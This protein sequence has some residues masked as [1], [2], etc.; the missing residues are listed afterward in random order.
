MERTI[1]ASLLMLA[2]GLHSSR[3]VA[4]D[5]PLIGGQVNCG[6]AG[7]LSLPSDGGSVSCTGTTTSASAYF[8]GGT[9][10]LR[11]QS[12]GTGDAGSQL[13]YQFEVSGPAGT[14]V[15]ITFTAE[16]QTSLSATSLFGR[17]FAQVGIFVRALSAGDNNYIDLTAC[18]STERCPN[19][20]QISSFSVAQPYSVVPNTVYE[21]YMSIVASGG[22]GITAFASVDPDI[23]IDFSQLVA[24]GLDPSQFALTVSP[25]TVAP[26]P[27]PASAWLL[28][29]GLLGMVLVTRSGLLSAQ[30]PA[31]TPLDSVM[32]DA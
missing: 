5:V 23:T 19:R 21:V 24:L 20:A 17:Y 25:D 9:S 8:V 31:S 27:L 18:T 14:N 22:P 29:S 6:S 12:D 3:A 32:Q 15:P 2:F 1:F 4:L 26:V 11:A 28:L 7:L 30:V 16:A 13:T 10:T